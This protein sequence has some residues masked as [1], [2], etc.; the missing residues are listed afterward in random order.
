M[1]GAVL[2]IILYNIEFWIQVMP[3]VFFIF[4]FAFTEQ[5]HSI[6]YFS[7]SQVKIGTQC[8][9]VGSLGCFNL[10]SQSLYTS[11]QDSGLQG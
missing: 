4:M 9:H 10:A 8:V 6:K 5:N 3:G 11:A 2:G 1:Q 7:N